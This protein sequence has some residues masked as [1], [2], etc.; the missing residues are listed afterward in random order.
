[1]PEKQ[2]QVTLLAHTPDP[3]KTCAL[4]ARTC[5]SAAEYDELQKLVTAKDQAGFLRRIVASGHLSVLEH[6]LLPVLVPERLRGLV[7]SPPGGQRPA[8]HIQV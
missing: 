6:S 3:E 8:M 7:Q 4:A 1:M 2:L 5:Y